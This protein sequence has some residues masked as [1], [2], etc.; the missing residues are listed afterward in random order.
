MSKQSKKSGESTKQ[1]IQGTADQRLLDAAR[2][3][4]NE[5]SGFTAAARDASNV[6][7]VLEMLR[8]LVF[9]P[10]S[11]RLIDADWCLISELLDDCA[12]RAVKVKSALDALAQ[13]ESQEA[14]N[15]QP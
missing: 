8:H 1:S 4:Q 15:V 11:G 7:A 13:F 5:C 3:A 6:A 2:E 12:E 10:S 9:D 14:V